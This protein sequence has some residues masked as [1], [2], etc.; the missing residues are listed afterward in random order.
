MSNTAIASHGIDMRISVPYV[1]DD[2]GL[3]HVQ[4]MAYI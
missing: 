4:T 2:I 1:W 3:V